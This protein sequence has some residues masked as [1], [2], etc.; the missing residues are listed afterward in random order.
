LHEQPIFSGLTSAQA[1][2]PFPL[3]GDF[4]GYI[5]AVL[6]APMQD[7][8]TQAKLTCRPQTGFITSQGK[9]CTLVTK[10]FQL[11][12]LQDSYISLAAMFALQWFIIQASI[13]LQLQLTP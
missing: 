12:C 7:K 8:M 3:Y 6:T 9:S 10:T 4:A 5:K 11:L 13:L 1:V 2:D